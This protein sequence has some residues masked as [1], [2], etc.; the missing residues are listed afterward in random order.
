MYVCNNKKALN[1]VRGGMKEKKRVAEQG[2]SAGSH[3]SASGVY[4]PIPGQ[5]GALCLKTVK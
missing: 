3:V 2:S 5:A 4:S 1:V